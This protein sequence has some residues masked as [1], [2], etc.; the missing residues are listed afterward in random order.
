M[1]NF[2]LKDTLFLA[3]LNSIRVNC[4]N[5]NEIQKK[6]TILISKNVLA[7][8]LRLMF[9]DMHM[10]K[11]CWD[12]QQ[13]YQCRFSNQS[14]FLYTYSKEHVKINRLF[15]LFMHWLILNSKLFS[16]YVTIN[17]FSTPSVAILFKG[18]GMQK[19]MTVKAV[20]L[21]ASVRLWSFFFGGSKFVRF[22]AKIFG[23]PSYSD[24]SIKNT[25]FLPFR[26]Y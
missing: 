7:Y 18:W 17:N 11:A 9:V 22:L 10:S 12:I 24:N 25:Y 8:V 20:Y 2:F 23:A 1:S 19:T 15:I 4:K 3:R 6:L 21:L 16:R 26:Q 5:C 13:S 14:S